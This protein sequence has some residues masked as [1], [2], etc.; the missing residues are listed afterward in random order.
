[1]ERDFRRKRAA[2]SSRRAIGAGEVDAGV[3]EQRDVAVARVA[4]QLGSLLALVALCLLLVAAI[5]VRIVYVVS[6]IATFVGKVLGG[7]G[8]A[9]D[10]RAAMASGLM[11]VI[12]PVVYRFPLAFYRYRLDVHDRDSARLLF[13]REGRWLRRCS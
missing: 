4:P 12:S 11:P 7:L 1:M 10:V 6:W 3:N 13:F 5:W 2:P 9:D 8:E